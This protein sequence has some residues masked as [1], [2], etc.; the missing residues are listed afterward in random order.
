MIQLETILNQ[1]DAL[2]N[3][4]VQVRA[5]LCAAE[6]KSHQHDEEIQSALAVLRQD[7][8]ASRSVKLDSACNKVIAYTQMIDKIREFVNTALPAT[9]KV[10]V[11]S[12][13]DGELVQLAGR[14]SWHFPQ[15]AGGAYAGYHPANSHAAIEHLEALR[16][17]GAGYLMIPATATWWL[18]HYVDFHRHLASRYLLVRSDEHCILYGLSEARTPSVD[19]HATADSPERPTADPAQTLPVSGNG[20][21]QLNGADHLPVSYERLVDQI[22]VAVDQ[23]IPENAIVVVVSKGDE[24]LVKLEGRRGWHYPQTEDGAYAG[25]YPADS[26]AA[27]Q[28][29]E[30]LRRQ[31]AAYLVFPRTAFWWLAHYEDFRRHLDARYQRIHSDTHCIIYTLRS[32]VI[33]E[34]LLQR[35]SL[36]FRG[37]L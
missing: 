33:F 14:E 16:A 6:G 5:L 21:H 23:A 1:I 28:H 11:I 35:F 10:L 3:R 7:L 36:S 2:K 34:R 29:L 13:G 9:A 24:D 27:I 32:R 18:T 25:Y 31:G 17:K 19:N 8:E 30:S 4:E 15:V 20:R 37:G 12:R 22:R 26:T